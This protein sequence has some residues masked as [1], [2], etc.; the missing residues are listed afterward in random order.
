MVGVDRVVSNNENGLI[1]Y[2]DAHH[3]EYPNESFDLVINIESSH[4]YND[5]EKFFKEVQR[6]LK[7]NGYFC[8][9]DLRFSNEVTK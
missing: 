2:S 5:P 1:K 4:L 9:A 8:M 3:I 6:V 7:P